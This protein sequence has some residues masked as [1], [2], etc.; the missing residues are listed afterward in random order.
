VQVPRFGQRGAAKG[1]RLRAWQIARREVEAQLCRASAVC[2][3]FS[4]AASRLAAVTI[5]R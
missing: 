5:R 2:S 4:S 3:L 1:L